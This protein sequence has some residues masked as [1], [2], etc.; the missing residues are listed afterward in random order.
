MKKTIII[1]LCIAFLIIL[2][3][4]WQYVGLYSATHEYGHETITLNKD[5]TFKQFFY[6]SNYVDSNE[7]TWQVESGRFYELNLLVL[8]GWVQFKTPWPFEHRKR[9]EGE[10]ITNFAPFDGIC[11]T[12]APDF[13]EFNPCR[14][15]LDY[16]LWMVPR[17]Q[18]A[19]AK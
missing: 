1:L 7:G 8:D 17:P 4:D 13:P 10:K 3:C 16:F 11:I 19:K 6:G 15:W 14:K 9:M 12:I 18:S 2:R 5:H